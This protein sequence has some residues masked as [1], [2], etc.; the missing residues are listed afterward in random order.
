M[1]LSCHDPHTQNGDLTTGKF[2]VKSNQRSAICTTCHTKSGGNWSWATSE[3]ST[4]TKSY[5]SAN[6]GG[7]AGLGAHTGYGTVIDNG[8]E[9]CHRPHSAPQA[10]RLL[11]AVNQRNVCFQCHGS[12]PLSGT[13]NLAA[14]FAKRP[15]FGH[16]LESSTSTI[17][18]DA[19]EVTS[20]PTNFSGTRRH[21]DC[22]DCHNPHAAAGTTH[23]EG[24]T[25]S[26]QIPA[27]SILSGVTGVQAPNPALGTVLPMPTIAQ[28]GYTVTTPV[29]YEYQICF[30]CHSSYAYGTT[31]PPAPSGGNQ[32]DV[33]SEFNPSNRSYH[34]V[35]GAPH[36]SRGTAQSQLKT[37]WAGITAAT[38]MYCSD[39]HGNNVTTAGAVRG[40]HGSTGQ[41]LLRYADSTW[42]TTGP[43]LSSNN[44]FCSNCHGNLTNSSYTNVHTLGE[45]QSVSCQ[46]C[47]SVVP[48]GLFRYGMIVLTTDPLPYRSS[49]ARIRTFTAATSPTSYQKSNCTT[50]AG[51]PGCH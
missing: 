28:T 14:E 32:T 4:S 23:V 2:L 31:P 9:S 3:H 30:K 45:H 51:S 39:C 11:K 12:V 33:V 50:I 17:V 1:C 19:K 22:S 35:W 26:G 43:T 29:V 20:S 21:V 40:P 44:G 47:H 36:L 27:N 16:T 10:Q 13:K 38:R 5:T 15:G 34:P 49:V 37:P 6:T 41:Y 8:C 24:A 42:N 18:H 48:H 7:V 46:V 25:N